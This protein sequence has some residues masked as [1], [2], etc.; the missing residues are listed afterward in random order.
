MPPQCRRGAPHP[1]RD[2]QERRPRGAAR[3]GRGGQD[4][5]QPARGGLHDRGRRG[6]HDRDPGRGRPE[7]PPR[8]D[9]DQLRQLLGHRAQLP[10][11]RARAQVGV[12]P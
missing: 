2:G 8:C 6:V 11:S 1:G 7:D 3:V 12:E 4:L 5:Q 10:G 9:P